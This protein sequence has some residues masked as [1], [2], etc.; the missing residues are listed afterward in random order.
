MLTSVDAWPKHYAIGIPTPSALTTEA[1]AIREHVAR[2]QR[3]SVG[4]VL[5]RDVNYRAS[6]EPI[7][8]PSH[9]VLNRP[10]DWIRAAADRQV[11]AEYSLLEYLI[12]QA[13][14][15]LHH[16]LIAHLKLLQ[17]HPR[18]ELL[19]VLKL[20]ATLQPGEAKRRPLRL[21]AGYGVDTK[22]F[23]RH[24]RLLIKLLDARFE[25]EAS[26]QGLHAFLDATPDGEH[27]LLMVPLQ[28]GLLPFKA[29]QVRSHELATLE[30]GSIKAKRILVVEN[31]Q[32]Q[33]M[34]P[35]LDNT[36]AILGS[37]LDLEWLKAPWLRDKHIAY[38][39]DIDTWGLHMLASARQHLP[40]VTALMMDK[41]TFENHADANAVL[42]PV[43][44][45][46]T[47]PHAL[48]ADEQ[49]LYS[50]LLSLEHGR[51]EQEYL[52]IDQVHEC[53]RDALLHRTPQRT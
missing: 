51:L 38:W 53:L 26:K 41:Q 27:W 48:N 15:E 21:L 33:H 23:E 31:R 52:D 20:G 3:V 12:S 47:P 4:E 25:G 7:K 1:T 28:T 43:V 24:R 34:L 11:S 6:S 37:G 10:S 46:D 44:A 5:W 32:C 40:D 50:W 16:S 18:E 8:M 13:D 19:T 17:G 30:Q 45:S 14:P 29:Q 39:G 2:W 35:Q 42:E 36:I 49:A 9:W 22:F